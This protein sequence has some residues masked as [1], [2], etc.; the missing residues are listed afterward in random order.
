[1]KYLIIFCFAA[2][3][4]LSCNNSTS[5]ESAQSEEVPTD[6]GGSQDDPDLVAIDSTIHGFYAWIEANG[7]SL[8]DINYVKTGKPATLDAAKLAAYF[9]RLKQSGYISQAY[10]DNETAYLKNLEATAWKT[11][12]VSEEPLTGL[13]Y[14]R[15]TCAQDADFT[16]WKTAPVSADGLGTDRSTA[17]MS[18]MEGG[19]ERTQQFELVKENGKWLISKILCE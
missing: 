2:L 15:F 18:G 14:D 16:F 11:Q 17:T 12:D 6:N 4:L 10:V 3:T 13:D 1:M 8:S 7:A 9:E 5:T 19:S